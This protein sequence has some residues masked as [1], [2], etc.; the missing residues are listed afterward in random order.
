MRIVL[1]GDGAFPEIVGRE[2]IRVE[3]FAVTA[4]E[5]GM[6]SGRPS[7]AFFIELPDGRVVMAE[8][9]MRLFQMAAAAFRAKY[10]DVLADPQ[11]AA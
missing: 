5:G 8:T 6:S 4:L 3:D 7:V 2:M 1:E 10:G 9:S 11:G